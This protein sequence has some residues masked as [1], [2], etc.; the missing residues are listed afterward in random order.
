M[1]RIAEEMHRGGFSRLARQL[2]EKLLP[3]QIY[4]PVA[5]KLTDL[6]LAT[7]KH[8]IAKSSLL[9]YFF[10]RDLNGTLRLQCVQIMFLTVSLNVLQ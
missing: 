5:T 6:A 3:N 9:S 1:L 2:K 10:I 7:N 4:Q 8:S